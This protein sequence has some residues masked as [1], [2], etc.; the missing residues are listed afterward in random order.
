MKV[1]DTIQALQGA[2]DKLSFYTADTEIVLQTNGH[3]ELV[4]V[5]SVE[6]VD[7]NV[8]VTVLEKIKVA[9]SIADF[10]KDAPEYPSP[11]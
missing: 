5:I 1:I 6:E 8:T 10:E 4:N 3:R 9:G 11:W 7:G 2:I